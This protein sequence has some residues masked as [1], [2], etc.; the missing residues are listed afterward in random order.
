MLV[1]YRSPAASSRLAIIAKRL[2]VIDFDVSGPACQDDCAVARHVNKS[3]DVLAEL[4][5][6]DPDSGMECSEPW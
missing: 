1:F 3:V 2:L 4:C 6:E 5:G